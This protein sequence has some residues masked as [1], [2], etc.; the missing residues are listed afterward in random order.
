MSQPI[1]VQDILNILN[2]A[3]WQYGNLY[4]NC[5]LQRYYG[6]PSTILRLAAYENIALSSGKYFS[7]PRKLLLVKTTIVNAHIGKNRNS[8]YSLHIIISS[9]ADTDDHDDDTDD[10]GAIYF[11][12]YRGSAA[13]LF[14][15]CSCQWLLL[16]A[17][18]Q[19]PV[20]VSLI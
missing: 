5:A 14:V 12:P 6:S 4:L 7:L 13:T 9:S 19:P 15:P 10:N 3:K 11:P 1:S 18:G 17:A 8:E 20:F 16:I 2:V